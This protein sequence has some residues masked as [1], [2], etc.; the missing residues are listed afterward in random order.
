[1]AAMEAIRLA[2]DMW[3]FQVILEGMTSFNG[4][5]KERAEV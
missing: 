2:R 5:L 1:M 3:W 4:T